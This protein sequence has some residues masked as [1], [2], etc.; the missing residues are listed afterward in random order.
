MGNESLYALTNKGMYFV[1][2]NSS[3]SDFSDVLPEVDEEHYGIKSLIVPEFPVLLRKKLSRL[4]GDMPY[5]K[6]KRR[7]SCSI[8]NGYK[9]KGEKVIKYLEN[10][11]FIKKVKGSSN[12]VEKKLDEFCS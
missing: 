9:L 2:G 10:K 7:L 12:T 8:V 11:G 6:L 1:L 4:N 3:I 5:K